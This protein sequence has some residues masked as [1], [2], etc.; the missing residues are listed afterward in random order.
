[1]FEAKGVN[2]QSAKYIAIKYDT[3][4]DRWQTA[5][6]QATSTLLWGFTG[7][8]VKTLLDRS[9]ED[10]VWLVRSYMSAIESW[11]NT[12]GCHAAKF[13]EIYLTLNQMVVHL[14]ESL[15]PFYMANFKQS[16]FYDEVND[17]W[18]IPPAVLALADQ[19][20]ATE[21]KLRLMNSSSSSSS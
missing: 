3:S 16:S 15:P 5:F 1:M 11:Q 2:N 17:T 21:T 19:A 10:T 13:S 8:N 20:A 12:L 4:D 18:R 7:T 9:P 14:I 6:T